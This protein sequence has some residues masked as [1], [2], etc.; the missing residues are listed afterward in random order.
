MFETKKVLT[1]KDISPLLTSINHLAIIFVCMWIAIPYVRSIIGVIFLLFWLFIWF[2]TTDMRWILKKWSLDLVF[3]LVFFITFIPYFLTGTL[4]YGAAGTNAITISFP[5]FLAGIFINHYYMY[6]KK[7]YKALGLIAICTIIFFIIG[8]F[9]TYLGLLDYPMASRELATGRADFIQ[10]YTKLGIG[11]FGHIYSVVFLLIGSLYPIIRNPSLFTLAHKALALL[12]SIVAFQ[13][14][15]QASYATSLLISI[16]GIILV[17]FA[18]NRVTLLLL[19]I[20]SFFLLV[21]VDQIAMGN[22]F[23]A[24]ADKLSW[25]YILNEKFTDLANSLLIDFNGG[26]LG[27]RVDLYLS[28]LQTF[29]SNPFFGILGPFS[30]IES[31]RIEGHSGWFDLLGF[32][33][34]FTGVPL[35]LTFYFNFKKHLKYY[36]KTS[37]TG[38]LL[39]I[40]FLFL[41]FGTINPVL[42]VIEIGFVIFCVIPAIPYIPYAFKREKVKVKVPKKRSV[43]VT[44]REH[45]I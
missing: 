34:L 30:H 2:I 10:M 41:L 35:F 12:F 16:L 42:Y 45:G 43:V 5:I 23:L 20:T 27:N 1:S 31:G 44:G 29:F 36:K 7:D 24:I 28:S 14:L 26:Q 25:N 39:V 21:V 37:F 38:F 22:F 17:V 32:Y 19:M 3:V 9:Q 11:G 33:G 13:M 6:Y 4:F 18:K 8:N 40:Y 15:I